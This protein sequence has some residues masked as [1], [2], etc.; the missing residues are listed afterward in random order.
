MLLLLALGLIPAPFQKKQRIETGDD[1]YGLKVVGMPKANRKYLIAELPS[2]AEPPAEYKHCGNGVYYLKE[3][4]RGVNVTAVMV[5]FRAEGDF[6]L[7]GD[8]PD[9]FKPGSKP[10]IEAYVPPGWV[11]LTFTLLRDSLT[12]QEIRLIRV[13]ELRPIPGSRL[14][15]SS[16]LITGGVVRVDRS[17]VDKDPYVTWEILP[18]SQL[19]HLI[20]RIRLPKSSKDCLNSKN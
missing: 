1:P 12:L 5:Y 7:R 19:S 16:G 18:E 4:V 2:G 14:Y 8:I 3:K 20:F 11:S 15:W 6:E 17:W 9:I 13:S 10:G